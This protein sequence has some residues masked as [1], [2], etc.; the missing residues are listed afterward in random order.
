[1]ANARFGILLAALVV[2]AVAAATAWGMVPMTAKVAHTVLPAV[3]VMDCSDQYEPHEVVTVVAAGY[4]VTPTEP[5]ND[6]YDTETYEPEEGDGDDGFGDCG[7][8]DDSGS[9]ADDC[10]ASDSDGLGTAADFR[11]DG[12]WWWNSDMYT[13]YSSNVLHH[14]MTDEWWIDADGIYRTAEGYVVC[15][16]DYRDYGEVFETPFGLGQVLDCGCSGVD[17]YVCW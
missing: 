11:R 8:S 12:V 17:V 1:M 5:Q 10:R 13:W 4:E 9:A 3:E 6:L 16:C 15:A 7:V 2:L 14:Y